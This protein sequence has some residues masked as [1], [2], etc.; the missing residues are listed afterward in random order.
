MFFCDQ[1]VTQAP[2][3]EE[4]K[5]AQEEKVAA[6]K[7][8]EEAEEN[9]KCLQD[10]QDKARAALTT[11]QKKPTTSS[12]AAKV[13]DAQAELDKATAAVEAAERAEAVA[14]Q[15]MVNARRRFFS[16]QDKEE[17]QKEANAPKKAA[18][19]YSKRG[20]TA[21]LEKK[22]PSGLRNSQPVKT[23]AVRARAAVCA[24][25]RACTQAQHTHARATGGVQPGQMGRPGRADH[26]LLECAGEPHAVQRGRHAGGG[27][28]RRNALGDAH[29]R[30]AVRQGTS[31]P[32]LNNQTP[33]KMFYR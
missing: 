31:Q 22:Y 27:R 16:I 19:E 14:I 17:D 20:T 15:E 12:K 26:G 2:P 3:T 6:E 1:V 28:P 8:K 32:V 24:R 11:A 4:F 33:C 29:S 10:K 23:R 30:R 13:S 9:V 7:R 21:V 25:A 5:K 18:Q